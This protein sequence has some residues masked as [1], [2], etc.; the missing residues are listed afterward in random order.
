M[1]YSDLYALSFYPYMSAH[2]GNPYPATTFD[3]L[4]SISSKPLAI[5]ET[6]YPAQSF[7]IETGNGLVTI[8]GSQDK[9]DNYIQNLLDACNRRKALF[10]IN[11]VLRDYDQLWKKL[12][13]PQ[14][15]GIAWR[16]NGLYDEDGNQRQAYTT[17][18]NYLKRSRE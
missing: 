18:K 2:L 11:F 6:G 16:D 13:S 7:S 10:V 8:S 5:A 17:W 9:Q 15:I 4:F 1:Q 14:D 3:D 12:G